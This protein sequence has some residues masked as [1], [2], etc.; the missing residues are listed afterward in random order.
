MP[1]SITLPTGQIWCLDPGPLRPLVDQF[2]GHL[3]S[4][5]H[6]AL[7]VRGYGDGARH[8]AVWLQQ[9]GVG[10][11]DV[12]GNTCVSFANH[13]CRCPGVRRSD[14]VSAKYA[15][16]ANRFVRFLSECGV[17]GRLALPGPTPLEP[18]VVLFQDWLHQHRGIAARTISKHGGMITRLLATLGTDPAHYTA[19][20]IR[21]AILT[22]SKARPRRTPRP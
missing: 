18:R 3:A 13:H 4:R 19:A 17:I 9:P 1:S 5:G 6:T 15:R 11:A 7:T 10:I 20:S 21:Q 22:K 12:D 16:R 2:T 8:F 14:R